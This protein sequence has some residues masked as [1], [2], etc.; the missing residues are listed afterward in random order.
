M[1]TTVRPPIILNS[2][3]VSAA[4]DIVTSGGFVRIATPTDTAVPAIY[5]P[6]GSSTL[7][8]AVAETAAVGTAVF[9]S[10]ASTYYKFIISQLNTITG[11]IEDHTVEYTSGASTSAAIIAAAL[12]AAIL[13]SSNLKSGSLFVTSS[14]ASTTI[15]ITAVTGHAVFTMTGVSNI[16]CTLGTPGVYPI[17]TAAQVAAVPNITGT[18]VSGHIYNT[19]VFQGFA[20]TSNL[21]T[22]NGTTAFTQTLYLDQNATN[23][24]AFLTAITRTLNG[25]QIGSSTLADP[26]L[27]SAV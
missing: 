19:L 25:L 21:L 26:E 14:G 18:A 24:A 6:T 12:N 1:N 27:Y 8:A 23:Y 22:T 13:A 17:G 11:N 5:Y 3:S 16:T 20:K 15:T 9:V 2:F 7:T 10:T 4:T